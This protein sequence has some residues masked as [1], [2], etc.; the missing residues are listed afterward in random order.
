LADTP[1]EVVRAVRRLDRVGADVIK[2]C[3]TGGMSEGAPTNLGLPADQV[4]L[5][6]AEMRRHRSQPVAA[7]AISEPGIWEAVRGG[8]SSVEHGYGLT[9]ELIGEM[10]ARRVVLVPTLATLNQIPEP[11]SASPET[12]GRK[13][14]WREIGHRAVSRAIAADLPIALWT[15][16]GIH[17]HGRNLDELG[18][19]VDAGMTP[20]Q[21][22]HAG[23]LVGSNTMGL[24]DHIGSIRRG[25]LADMV[26]TRVDPLTSIHALGDPSS[27][28]LVWQSGRVVKDMDRLAPGAPPA[29]GPGLVRGDG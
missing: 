19:L 20:L 9:E 14:E 5:I 11:G 24:A 17:P 28:R 7:H 3:T 2:V 22:I 12:I 29:V 15:D 26:L 23:T 18:L 16:A 8:A 21:A 6:V 1:D 13:R 25:K 4:A 27:I 10:L